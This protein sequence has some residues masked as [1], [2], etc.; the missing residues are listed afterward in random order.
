MPPAPL[1]Y[2]GRQR[3]RLES[4]ARDHTEPALKVILGLMHN[5]SVHR[6]RAEALG[7]PAIGI[8]AGEIDG[9]VWSASDSVTFTCW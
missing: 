3:S 9:P 2:K 4:L 1:V 6:L 5:E 8:D 7:D